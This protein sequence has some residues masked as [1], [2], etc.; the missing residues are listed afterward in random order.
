MPFPFVARRAP[1]SA[2]ISLLALVLCAA[3]SVTVYASCGDWLAAP[4]HHTTPAE[5]HSAR[6]PAT[7]PNAWPANPR[8][9]RT[10]VDRSSWPPRCSQSLLH[11]LL[12]LKGGAKE[13]GLPCVPPSPWAT[14]Q[15]NVLAKTLPKLPIGGCRGPVCDRGPAEPPTAPPAPASEISR[16]QM[17]W[18]ASV[19]PPLGERR[20]RL[21]FPDDAR[22]GRQSPFVLERP[23]RR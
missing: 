4:P 12:S 1:L 2:A 10:S 11:A 8:V 23:P 18:F 14:D 7:W 16:D 13:E 19:S 5:T 21:D 15:F 17:A 20:T 9:D 3:R 6:E 22:R